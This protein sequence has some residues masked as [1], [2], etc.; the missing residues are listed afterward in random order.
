MKKVIILILASFLYVNAFSQLATS[1]GDRF[2][3]LKMGT[4]DKASI[5]TWFGFN[6]P[7]SQPVPTWNGTLGMHA[8]NPQTQA[9]FDSAYFYIPK[10]EP[11][12]RMYLYSSKKLIDFELPTMLTDET[13]FNNLYRLDLEAD[14]IKFGRNRIK[15]LQS[16]TNGYITNFQYFELLDEFQNWSNYQLNIT[17]ATGNISGEENIKVLKR[18][19][20]GYPSLF[21]NCNAV[22]SII[23]INLDSLAG[24]GITVSGLNNGNTLRK[25]D[26]YVNKTNNIQNKI[27]VSTGNGVPFQIDTVRVDIN[28]NWLEELRLQ[29]FTAGSKVYHDLKNIDSLAS[30]WCNA[31]NADTIDISNIKI[32]D[33]TALNTSQVNKFIFPA[34]IHDFDCSTFVID[35]LDLDYI[36][37]DNAI[38]TGISVTADTIIINNQ[39]FENFEI[40]VIYGGDT[41]DLSGGTFKNIGSLY[42]YN[43]KPVILPAYMD[44]ISVHCQSKIKS[45]PAGDTLKSLQLNAS[46]PWE[47][48]DINDYTLDTLELLNLYE[49]D[50]LNINTGKEYYRGNH[51]AEVTIYCNRTDTIIF[52]QTQMKQPINFNVLYPDFTLDSIFD[53]TNYYAL[54]S[55]NFTSNSSESP[56]DIILPN[57]HTDSII[58]ITYT[59]VMPYDS[60]FDFS[61]IKTPKLELQYIPYGAKVKMP[62]DSVSTEMQRFKLQNTGIDSVDLS[63]YKSYTL[64]TSNENVFYCYSADSL[65]HLKF[66]KNCSPYRLYIAAQ[67]DK[68]VDCFIGVS[69][70]GVTDRNS[71]SIYMNFGAKPAAVVNHFLYDLDQISISGY[72]GRRIYI[73]NG[74]NATPDASSGG[75]DGIAAKNSLVAK[76]FTVY[77]N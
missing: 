67:S 49:V 14:T 64:S 11:V 39:S 76:G 42:T 63:Y 1:A 50:T 71:Q 51:D 43:A 31:M 60:I 34:G 5:T 57:M 23:N 35:T 56:T 41:L 10:Y 9:S 38:F 74:S 19:N 73:N 66:P 46:Q 30:F 26:I 22:D 16:G 77:T 18:N 7:N 36:L 45:L 4:L 47:Y 70:A 55:I 25:I 53:F 12:F 20:D 28:N 21:L 3:I 32:K 44:W 69:G 2:T 40:G 54:K 68:Y 75:Y 72:T 61:T 65:V 59:R 62:T 15:L 29:N 48:F 13:G 33:F 8:R 6:Y 52:E 24:A 27:T 37:A 58:N 17:S